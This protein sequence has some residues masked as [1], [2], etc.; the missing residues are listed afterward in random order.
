MGSIKFII[1]DVEKNASANLFFIKCLCR[2]T[3][4]V[5]LST[6]QKRLSPIEC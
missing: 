5:T 4:D 3:I 2:V 1:Q 6:I